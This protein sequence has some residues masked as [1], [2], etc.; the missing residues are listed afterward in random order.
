[1]QHEVYIKCVQPRTTLT[2]SA[3]A[4]HVFCEPEAT[5]WTS[6]VCRGDFGR[7][8]HED[9]LDVFIPKQVV[10]LSGKQVMAVLA[11]RKQSIAIMYVHAPMLALLG[12]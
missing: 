8:G 2:Y 11:A 12:S 10:G 9:V 6:C 4:W 7:L 5:A 3:A 1:M